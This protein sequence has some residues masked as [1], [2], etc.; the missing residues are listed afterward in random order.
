M[1]ILQTTLRK[2]KPLREAAPAGDGITN[3]M[4]YA[5]GLP[6]LQPCGTVTT[7]TV[8][9]VDGMPHLVLEWPVN[10]DATD[11]VFNVESSTDLKKWN[12][13]GVVTPTGS[14]G[15][16]QDPGGD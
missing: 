2:T 16:Y 11:V 9:N 15:E 13:E 1:T 12:D 6:P 7:L 5:T 14:R 10:P 4:K 3:L 8:R